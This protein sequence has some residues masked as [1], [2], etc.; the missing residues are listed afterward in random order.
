[1]ADTT[2]ELSAATT[3]T[4]PEERI[5]EEQASNLLTAHEVIRDPLHRDIS[6]TAL[7]RAAIDTSAFQRLRWLNQLGP[8]QVVYPGAV[9]T[10]FLHSIGTLHTADQLVQIANRNYRTYGKEHHLLHIGAYPHML[11]RMMALLHDVAHMPFGHTLEDE[12]NLEKPEWEDD[13]RAEHWLS[14]AEKPEQGKPGEILGAVKRF[15][16]ASGISLNAAQNFAEDVRKYVLFHGD[17]SELEFPFVVDL[18][19]NTLCADLLDYLYRDMYFCG[20]SERAGD[21]VTKYL[22]IVRC[23]PG[24]HDTLAPSSEEAGSKGRVVLLTYRFEKEHTAGGGLKLVPKPEIISEAIDLLRR[25]YALAEKVYFHRTK[26]AASAMLISAMG[27]ASFKIQ[28]IYKVSDGTFLSMLLKDTNPRTKHLAAAYTTRRLYQPAYRINYRE[29]CDSDPAS[30]KLWS[31][32]ESD[33][34][35]PGKRRDIEEK[36]E[37]YADLEAGTV[38]VYCPDRRMNLKE[39]EMLVQSRPGGDIKQ[40]AHILDRSWTMEMDAINQR[41]APLW[42]LFVFVDPQAIDATEAY[43]P[44]VRDF[45]ALCEELLGFPNSLDSERDVQPSPGRPLAEQIAS[46]VIRKFQEKSKEEV[47][48]NV[49]QDLVQADR[50]GKDL[51]DEMEQALPLLMRARAKPN[52]KAG[53][54]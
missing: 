39:F 50:R 54:D 34:R 22:A 43:S 15:L 25:R 42:S 20:L 10:R 11:V 51:V 48:H 49:F 19:G 21:R 5:S 28:E 9:H 1:M 24:P 8:T 31:K 47:P 44:S 52:R 32:Y 18:V 13:N 29:E 40:L 2:T 23:R 46:R 35:D 14:I 12:G 17:Q 3:T 38:C 36:L 41:F 30:K 27:S 53:D 26:L 4:Q 45:S 33:Y 7:E 6:I 37:K 16:M